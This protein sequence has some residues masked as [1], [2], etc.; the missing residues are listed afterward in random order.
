[1]KDLIVLVCA[2]TVTAAICSPVASSVGGKHISFNMSESEEYSASSYVQDGL[3]AIWDGLENAGW[4]SHVDHTNEWA[5]LING[6]VLR[7]ANGIDGDF[8][9]GCMDYRRTF[10]NG[11]G[12]PETRTGNRYYDKMIA[13]RLI[14]NQGMF[15][16]E[17]VHR[18]RVKLSPGS[19]PY[20]N[21]VCGLFG[22]KSSHTSMSFAYDGKINIF[23]NVLYDGTSS[24]ATTRP[25]EYDVLETRT[26]VFDSDNLVS[27]VLVDG[28]IVG[29]GTLLAGIFG[30]S[31]SGPLIY[32]NT[33]IGLVQYGVSGNEWTGVTDLDDS[34]SDVYCIRIYSRPL[35]SEECIFNQKI[36]K[37]RFDQ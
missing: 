24:I 29:T 25:F 6:F 17:V 28:E 3:V 31:E 35:S 9:R 37:V 32:L 8:S 20:Q 34:T 4:E 7:T 12:D 11:A 5:D 22:L 30:A 16:I 14:V 15:T 13:L 1:M 19:W 33:C 2:M 10:Y 26:L 21:Y 23:R 36:N 18:P 27:Y